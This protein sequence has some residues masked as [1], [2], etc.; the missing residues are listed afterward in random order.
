M[1]SCADIKKIKRELHWKPKISF[2]EGISIMMNEIYK[3]KDAPLWTP[4]K[5]K[6]ATK[7]WFKYLSKKK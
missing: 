7:I 3:W 2:K 4:K 5:I 6:T 1:R